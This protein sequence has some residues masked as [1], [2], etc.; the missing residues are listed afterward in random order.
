MLKL[1]RVCTR[2][3]LCVDCDEKRCIHAGKIISDCPMYK[4]DRPGEDF[5]DC[6]TC[7]F[8]KHIQDEMIRR[9]ECGI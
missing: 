3:N 7:E 2:Q 5:E 6:E 1:L 4:C 8:I 9:R